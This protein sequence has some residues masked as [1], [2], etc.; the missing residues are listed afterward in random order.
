M[1][2]VKQI[3]HGPSA[4]NFRVEHTILRKKALHAPQPILE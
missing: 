2:S 3:N 4:I 1:N